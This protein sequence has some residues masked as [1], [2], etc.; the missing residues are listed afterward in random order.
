MIRHSYVFVNRKTE[1]SKNFLRRIF[2]RQAVYSYG[3]IPQSRAKISVEAAE[4][5]QN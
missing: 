4:K 5:R 1:I 2:A 3:K